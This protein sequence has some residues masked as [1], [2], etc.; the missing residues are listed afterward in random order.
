MHACSIGLPKTQASYQAESRIPF[1]GQNSASGSALSAGSVSD[2]GCHWLRPPCPQPGLRAQLTARA[3]SKGSPP[4]AVPEAGS[5]KLP[6]GARPKLH[7]ADEAENQ[8]TCRRCH[9]KG[10]IASEQGIEPCPQC[11]SPAERSG[12][13]RMVLPAAPD[14]SQGAQQDTH[15]GLQATGKG[16]P[17]IVQRPRKPRRPFSAEHCEKISE[18]LQDR[19]YS[20]K[21]AEHRERIADSMRRLQADAN[22]KKKLSLALKGRSKACSYCGEVGHQRHH[23][24]KYLNTLPAEERPR[25]TARRCGLCGEFGHYSKAC[26]KRTTS[27]SAPAQAPSQPRHLNPARASS[28]KS[29]APASS[30]PQLR[31]IIRDDNAAAEAGN[32]EQTYAA[33]QQADADEAAGPAQQD[34]A[35]GTQAG[36]LSSGMSHQRP[37]DAGQ[38]ESVSTEVASNGAE[39][40]AAGTA[41]I[42]E[43]AEDSTATSAS[44]SSAD[45]DAEQQE[46]IS[47]QGRT[48]KVSADAKRKYAERTCGFCGE[49]GHD[50]RNCPQSRSDLDYKV[51]KGR[52]KP[53]KKPISKLEAQ[54]E[55]PIDALPPKPS[56]PGQPWV[57]PLPLDATEVAAQVSFAVEHAYRQGIKNQLVDFPL[58]A[59]EAQ[60]GMMGDSQGFAGGVSESFR[61]ARPTVERFLM[62]LKQKDG[63]QGRLAAEWLNETDCVGA[64]QSEQLAAVLFPTADSLGELRN[65]QLDGLDQRLM[66]V[67][68]PQWSTSGQIVSD[69]GFGQARQDAEKLVRSF[70]DIYSL[71]RMSV[72]GDEVRLLHCYPGPWQVM[73]VRRNGSIVV[74]GVDDAPPAYARMVD[75]LRG[76]KGSKT[77]QTWVNR[78]FPSKR[79]GTGRDLIP[80]ST[81]TDVQRS[82]RQPATSE[83]KPSL[84]PQQHS[85]ALSKPKLAPG[86]QRIFDN[87]FADVDIVTG[88]RVRDLRYEPL[89]QLARWQ[90]QIFGSKDDQGP[91]TTLGTDTD[92]EN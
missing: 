17:Q 3:N 83:P 53:F 47:R 55:K 89:S 31:H 38:A 72:N 37:Q 50:A 88:A 63:L 82:V 39:P 36:G 29:A 15:G 13:K 43:A 46:R 58:P 75:L 52:V 69:F 56:D 24:A 84:Q 10:Y 40:A 5:S 42:A 66:M 65:I 51:V 6:W 49:K 70:Q 77:S 35:Y 23:C 22:H 64:W 74:A 1:L 57:F 67:I 71:R 34:Q 4:I 44:E 33:A 80:P 76:V 61:A 18:A 78:V 73:L 90:E 79:F 41:A 7:S 91:N 2:I 20:P 62:A 19:V 9:G 11:R 85:P 12:L 8:G 60:Y 92:H 48:I 87:R 28:P 14:R 16:M 45:E 32:N 68:N 27:L 21:T 30:R 26:P 54:K 86:E 59:G 25:S 81:L